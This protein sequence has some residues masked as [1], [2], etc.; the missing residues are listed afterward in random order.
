[1]NVFKEKKQYPFIKTVGI[2][3]TNRCNL[4]CEH[5]Y[6][7]RMVAKEIGVYEMQKILVAFPNLESTNFGTGESILNRQFEDIVNLLYSKG[8]RIAIT[9]NGLSVNKMSDEALSK[10]E[11]VDLSLDF[12]TAELHD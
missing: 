7:R 12:P 11:D 9:S 3:L 5:C 6:S 10:F 4:N 8:I 2:G 1:M